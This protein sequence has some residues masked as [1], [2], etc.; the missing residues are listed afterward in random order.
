MLLRIDFTSVFKTEKNGE[1]RISTMTE[2]QIMEGNKEKLLI[3]IF[4]TL[5]SSHPYLICYLMLLL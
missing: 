1:E 4:F 2:D 5:K 3:I